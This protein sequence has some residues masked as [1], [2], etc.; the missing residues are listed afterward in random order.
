MKK[1]ILASGSLRRKQ[2]LEQIQ[3]PFDVIIGDYEE[4]MTLDLDPI[5]LA[6]V[7]S[8]GKAQDVSQKCSEGIVIG[9]DTFIALDGKI[10]G[11]PKDAQGACD[12]LR[13]LSGKV[14]SVIT[15]LTVIDAGNGE[16]ISRAKEVRVHIKDL[17][18]EEIQSYV[19]SG[20][21]LDKAGSYAIQGLGSKIVEKIDGDY[22]AVMGLPICELCSVLSEFG[23][24]TL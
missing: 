8:L 6:K 15:G 14:H 24:E 5:E 20:E 22:Y 13:E 3:L 17:T 10:M 18:D 4:D 23:V 1:I 12:M 9:A 2:I 7:L 11:K 19:D 21:P 16:V